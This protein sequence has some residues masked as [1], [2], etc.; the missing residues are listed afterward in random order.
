MKQK[1]QRLITPV[2][3]ITYVGDPLPFSIAASLEHIG[4]WSV[5]REPPL[6]SAGS[7]KRYLCTHS[8]LLTRMCSYDLCTVTEDPIPSMEMHD[9]LFLRYQLNPYKPPFLPPPPGFENHIYRNQ[10]PYLREVFV[11]P[12]EV[13]PVNGRAGLF[14]SD[15]MHT[16]CGINVYTKPTGIFSD[17]HREEGEDFV[18]IYSSIPKIR[19]S[20]QRCFD[21][22]FKSPSLIVD[23]VFI[24][25]GTLGLV[26]LNELYEL[27]VLCTEEVFNDVF[28]ADPYPVLSSQ[29]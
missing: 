25:W 29:Y 17:F 26:S 22:T 7:A 11:E 1:R 2:F 19:E 20:L 23:D 8:K 28:D 5:Y 24:S 18:L 9:Q 27:G 4:S 3:E 16:V 14:S 6:I 21:A 12:V 13:D 15:T 10:R